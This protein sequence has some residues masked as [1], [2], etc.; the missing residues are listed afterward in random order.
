MPGVD[1]VAPVNMVKIDSVVWVFF[2][3]FC[4]FCSFFFVSVKTVVFIVDFG[5]VIAL[6]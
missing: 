2:F 4:F 5:P 6:H 1:Y 3:V